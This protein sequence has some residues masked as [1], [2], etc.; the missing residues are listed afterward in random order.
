[1]TFTSILMYSTWQTVTS[2]HTYIYIYI[3]TGF[4][5]VLNLPYM[6][7]EIVPSA[8]FNRY[9]SAFI[10]IKFLDFVHRL[11]FY[12]QKTQSFGNRSSFRNVVVSVRRNPDDG[13]S[14]EA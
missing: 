9:I 13:Q 12:K 11:D 14:P 2:T 4:D 1:M 7:S 3:F 8:N 10:T 6:H 5:E